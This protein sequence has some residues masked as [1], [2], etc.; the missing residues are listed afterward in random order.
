MGRKDVERRETYGYST[1]HVEARRMW[2]P[3]SQGYIVRLHRKQIK[4]QGL[5]NELSN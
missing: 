1:L 2:V 3:G 5:E 4:Q